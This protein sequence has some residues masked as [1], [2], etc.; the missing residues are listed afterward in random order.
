LDAAAAIE[1]L[2]ACDRHV[3]HAY[4]IDERSQRHIAEELG[5]SQMQISR[6]LARILRRLRAQTALTD[7][8]ESRAM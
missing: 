3:L 1:A 2:D 6:T 7:D 5:V 8:G 4:F